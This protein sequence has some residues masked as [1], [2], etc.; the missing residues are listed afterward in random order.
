MEVW[1]A[2]VTHPQTCHPSS[3]QPKKMGM[4]RK[5]GSL[6]NLVMSTGNKGEECEVVL[7]GTLNNH[8]KIKNRKVLGLESHWIGIMMHT[9]GGQFPVLGRF[10]LQEKTCRGGTWQ[11]LVHSCTCRSVWSSDIQWEC[12]APVQE[13]EH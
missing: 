11:I 4:P 1:Q 8:I 6:S 10:A 7:V 12:P 13:M 2:G 9:L 5:G 3:C